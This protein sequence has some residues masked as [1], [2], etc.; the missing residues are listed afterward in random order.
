MAG[1]RRQAAAGSVRT[2]SGSAL[3]RRQGRGLGGVA[4]LVVERRELVE[5]LLEPA[6]QRPFA[7]LEQLGQLLVEPAVKTRGMGELG[8]VADQLLDPRGFLVAQATVNQ[9]LN[10]KLERSR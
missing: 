8:G 7:G 6:R 2:P 10:Q 4:R 9:I 5:Q 1:Q 3:G